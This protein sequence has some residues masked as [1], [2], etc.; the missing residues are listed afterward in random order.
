IRSE[1]YLRKGTFSTV[2]SM[3]SKENSD[4]VSAVNLSVSSSSWSTDSKA[5]GVVTSSVPSC[6]DLGSLHNNFRFPIDSANGALMLKQIS[7]CSPTKHICLWFFDLNE[8][9]CG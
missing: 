5:I 3:P 1:K 4:S 6:T 2:Y 9:S 7:I 8:Y